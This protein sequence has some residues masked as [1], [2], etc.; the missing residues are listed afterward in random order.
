MGKDLSTKPIVI[1]SKSI[2][3]RLGVLKDVFST[4]IV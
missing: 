1:I 3:D 2:A 4:E